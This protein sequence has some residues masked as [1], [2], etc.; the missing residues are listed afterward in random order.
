[1]DPFGKIIDCDGLVVDAAI[2]AFHGADNGDFEGRVSVARGAGI[3]GRLA[4]LF[5]FP[6][7][8]RDRTMR[9]SVRG[10]PDSA[11][12]QR[13]F[14]GHLL[15]SRIERRGSLLLERFGPVCLIMCLRDEAGALHVDVIGGTLCGLRMPRAVLPHSDSVE[16]GED[17]RLQFDISAALPILGPMIRYRGWLQ[18]VD[19]TPLAMPQATAG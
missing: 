16:T 5:G 9:M 19:E 10:G 14:D 6:P 2:R 17:G 13:D 12:W 7:A 11:T 4:D 1:M 15:T 3:A 18:P 8:M